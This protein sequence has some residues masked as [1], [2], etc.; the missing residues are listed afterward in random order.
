M[1]LL[2]PEGWIMRTTI[3]LEEDVLLAAKELA[4]QRGVSIGKV[5]SELA[6]QA[7]MP[8]E[9]SALRNGIPLFPVRAGAAVVTPEL[10]RQLHDEQV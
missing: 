1:F 8:S 7:L 2:L 6:R 3:D 4:R 10:V 9:A 5:I